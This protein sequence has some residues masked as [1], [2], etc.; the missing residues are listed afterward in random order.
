MAGVS[1]SGVLRTLANDGFEMFTHV[2]TGPQVGRGWD[3]GRGQGQGQGQGQGLS[4]SQHGQ[5]RAQAQAW[6]RDLEG[7]ECSAAVSSARGKTQ[8][9]R[10]HVSDPRAGANLVRYCHEDK[11]SLRRRSLRHAL[12]RCSSGREP[13]LPH[14]D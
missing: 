9:T 7:G 5:H 13:L 2:G 3:R 14:T 12:Q 10:Q 6:A 4:R 11:L 1:V 8:H